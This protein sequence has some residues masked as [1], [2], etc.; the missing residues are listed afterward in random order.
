MVSLLSADLE[1][2]MML[3]RYTTL[4]GVLA[5]A[6]MDFT[7]LDAFLSSQMKKR[8]VK[9]LVTVSVKH[10]SVFIYPY[11]DWHIQEANPPI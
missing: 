8:Q 9:V 7:Q 6:D 11:G 2:V 10:L 5:S 4:I 1:Y 3:K